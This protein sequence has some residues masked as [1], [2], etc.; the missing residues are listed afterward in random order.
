V[1]EPLFKIIKLESMLHIS[2]VVYSWA[3][4]GALILEDN[5]EWGRGA[6]FPGTAFY[7]D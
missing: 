4:G 2:A 5:E 1:S 3:S 6:P 7:N